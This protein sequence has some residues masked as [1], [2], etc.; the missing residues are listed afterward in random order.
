[1]S[2]SD[3]LVWTGNE[4][5]TGTK[6]FIGMYWNAM[7]TQLIK[8]GCYGAFEKPCPEP[9]TGLGA[10][11]LHREKMILVYEVLDEKARGSI[12]ETMLPGTPAG[13][14]VH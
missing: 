3:E 6:T 4:M 5:F 8:A 1:M 10:P 14:F 7:V 2:K 13:L 9:I 11:A 12:C